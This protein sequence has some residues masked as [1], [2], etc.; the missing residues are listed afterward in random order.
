SRAQRLLASVEQKIQS[1][2]IS[3]RAGLLSELISSLS[4]FTS[5]LSEPSL[6]VPFMTL[7]EI[8]VKEF[9]SDPVNESDQDCQLADEQVAMIRDMAKQVFNTCQAERSG[10]QESLAEVT[11]LMNELRLWI[12]DSD[13]SFLWVGDSFN[14]TS[15]TDTISTVF[16]DTTAGTCIL[17]PDTSLSLSN[18]IASITIDKKYSEGGIPGN[19]MEIRA[20]GQ[21]AFTGEQQEPRPILFDDTQP[22][23]DDLTAVLDGNPNTWFEWERVYCVFPQPTIV[24]RTAHIYDPGGKPFKTPL[25]MLGWSCFIKWPGDVTVDEGQ[26]VTVQGSKKIKVL[27]IITTKKKTQQIEKAGYPLAYFKDTDRRDLLLGL[28][29]ELDQPRPVSWLQL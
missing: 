14:D 21:A 1:G 12:S 28:V 5:S 10:L 29:I 13:S 11:N 15:K 17:Q 24:A 19:N 25:D 23:P 6:A 7:D 9:V 4:D 8:L 20:P 22:T 27:G 16:V 2:Q 18:N 26:T 3:T